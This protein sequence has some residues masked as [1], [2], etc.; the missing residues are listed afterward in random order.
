MSK[1]INIYLNSKERKLVDDLKVK[2]RLSLTTIV[3]V[4]TKY[5]FKYF[6]QYA[7]EKNNKNEEDLKRLYHEYLYLKGRKTSIKEP[8]IFKKENG[9]IYLIGNEYAKGQ[10]KSRFVTNSL[11]IYLNKTIENYVKDKEMVQAYWN[12][13]NKELLTRK[14]DFWDYNQ[15]VRKQRRMLRENKEYFKKALEK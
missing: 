9:G 11:M 13:I 12:N 2:Y 1:T 5:T 8:Q 6:F 7:V 3:D 15:Y 10:S 14:D 4:I